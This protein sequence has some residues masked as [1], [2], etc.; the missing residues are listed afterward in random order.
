MIKTIFL[1]FCMSLSASAFATE[2]I[3]MLLSNVDNLKLEAHL[4]RENIWYK[5]DENNSF[6]VK[7]KDVRRVA[8]LSKMYYPHK[9]KRDKAVFKNIAY[10][11]AINKMNIANIQYDIECINGN[12][13]IL[14]ERT[15]LDNMLDIIEEIE[16]ELPGELAGVKTKCP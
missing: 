9:D 4:S 6:I 13:T 15:Y 10:M 12:F 1:L 7:Q 2:L 16:S 5:K 14:W 8:Q 11:S 3:T